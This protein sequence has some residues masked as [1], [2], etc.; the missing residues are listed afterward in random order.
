MRIAIRSRAWAA[1][2][3]LLAFVAVAAGPARPAHADTHTLQLIRLNCDDEAETFSDEVLIFVNG[4]FIGSRG[5]LDGGDWWDFKPPPTWAF[6]FDGTILVQAY[7]NDGWLI[8]AVTVDGS[9]AGPND[10]VIPWNG[11]HGT[12]YA[13]RLTFHVT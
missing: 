1:M 7:E 11:H 5:N 4:V 9:Q 10:L 3:V 8:G 13:Y 12:D 2:A 6:Q